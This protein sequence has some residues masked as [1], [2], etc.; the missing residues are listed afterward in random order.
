MECPYTNLMKSYCISSI[1]LLKAL[2]SHQDTRNTY[3]EHACRVYLVFH[4]AVNPQ[5]KILANYLG[6][7][8]SF[9]LNCSK[10][11]KLSPGSNGK[12]LSICGKLFY[13]LAKTENN[14]NLFPE[15]AQ[16]DLVAYKMKC[17]FTKFQNLA[18][19]EAKLLFYFYN[20]ITLQIENI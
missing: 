1:H 13:R 10:F 12:S 17:I 14:G 3:R 2:W 16:C 18:R 6:D 19:P 8:L 11:A 15:L 20:I 4:S 5:S 7:C 9:V